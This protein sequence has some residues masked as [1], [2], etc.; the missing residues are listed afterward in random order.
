MQKHNLESLSLIDTGVTD[1]SLEYLAELKNLRS[2]SS[3]GTLISQTG[4]HKLRQAVPG[5]R[6]SAP[7]SETE[8][9]EEIEKL[10]AR[11]GTSVD[12]DDLALDDMLQQLAR[13]ADVEIVLDGRS[14]LMAGIHPNTLIT[15]KVNKTS[16]AKVLEAVLKPLGLSYE[17]RGRAIVVRAVPIVGTAKHIA[18][19]VA[20]TFFL[21][22]VETPDVDVVLDLANGEMLPIADASEFARLGKGDLLYDDAHGGSLGFV[23][24]AE[25]AN[26]NGPP[27]S[28]WKKR[29]YKLSPLPCQLRIKTAE[30]NVFDVT[31]LSAGKAGGMNDERIP[32]NVSGIR[33][34]YELADPKIVPR[35]PLDAMEGPGRWRAK[36]HISR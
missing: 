31:I 21:P 18:K 13:T 26:W 30:D 36:F 16:L 8:A 35:A 12:V 6:L 4:L 23:R 5:I 11:K 24:G 25:T 22:D 7:D 20:K 10:L 27:H 19:P 29:T 1:A 17:I 28:L 14:L 2:L 15:L 3:R 32:M 34:K 9:R 33:L